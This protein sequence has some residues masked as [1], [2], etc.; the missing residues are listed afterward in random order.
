VIFPTGYRRLMLV[1][2]RRGNRAEALR[3]CGDLRRLLRDQLGASPAPALQEL[4]RSL[5]T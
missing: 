1:H 3:V 2:D 4:H 5:L